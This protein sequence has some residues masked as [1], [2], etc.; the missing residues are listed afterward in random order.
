MPDSFTPTAVA[1]CVPVRN[2]A[3]LLPALLDALAAQRGVGEIAPT[4]CFLLDDCRDGSAAILAAFAR[5]SALPVRVA[6]GA[7]AGR[8]NAGRARRAAMAL[9]E[10]ALAGHARA[11]LLTTDADS[12]PAP[13]WVAACCRSLA[14]CDVVVGRIVRASDPDGGAQDR[15]D[16]YY[17]RLYALRRRHDPVAWEVEPGHHHVGGANLG[18]R[19]AAYR[20]LGG[21]QPLPAGEDGAI[22]D[23]AHR[24]GLRVRRDR[25]VLVET[26]PRRHGRAVQGL[27]DHLRA[28]GDDAAGVAVT[29]PADAAWQYRGHAAARASHARLHD[30]AT[31]ARLAALLEVDAAHIGRV[32]AMA[33]NAEAFATHVV[34]AAPGGGRRVTL[35]EAEAALALLEQAVQERAA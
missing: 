17:H 26:S 23:A 2:E 11:A 25:G 9:G 14:G 22:V 7:F 34:P 18:F 6:R 29:H 31:V 30:A 20:A 27:A 13:D 15:L 21:F 19:A 12:V 33:A 24:L 1:V 16:A 3:V 10:A 5:G 4:L 8:P 28:L 32:A 35:A